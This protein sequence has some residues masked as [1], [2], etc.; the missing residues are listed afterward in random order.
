MVVRWWVGRT[1][2][3]HVHPSPRDD[4]SPPPRGEPSPSDGSPPGGGGGGD[5]HQGGE[6][7]RAGLDG[8]PR[9]GIPMG[10]GSEAVCH[11]RNAKPRPQHQ[12]CQQESRQ[13]S[14]GEALS[15]RHTIYALQW[16]LHRADQYHP[17]TATGASSS[18]TTL[19]THKGGGGTCPSEGGPTCHGPRTRAHSQLTRWWAPALAAGAREVPRGAC[20]ALELPISGADALFVFNKLDECKQQVLYMALQK[21]IGQ[22]STPNP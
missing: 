21:N 15:Q 13:T 18:R 22:H 6:G 5:G 19:R 4:G 9:G 1:F 14:R 7:R 11:E 17:L 8:P 2:P 16:L 12:T 10:K 3:P 20:D